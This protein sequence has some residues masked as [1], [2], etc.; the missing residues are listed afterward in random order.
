STRDQDAEYGIVGRSGE[1][2]YLLKALNDAVDSK[3]SMVLVSGEPGIGKSR[4]VHRLAVLAGERAVP[5]LW[6]RC[7]ESS[8]APPCWPWVE[9]LN[10]YINAVGAEKILKT[11]GHRVGVITQLHDRLAHRL[12]VEPA[13]AAVDARAQLI[14]T[15]SML[16]V[17]LAETQPIVLI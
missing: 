14:D 7:W 2:N 15:V 12:G 6:G 1:L 10:S 11:L 3:G 17:Q 13:V 8:G 16:L 4:L 5:V 9:V